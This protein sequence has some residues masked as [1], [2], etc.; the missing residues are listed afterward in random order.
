MDLQKYKWVFTVGALVSSSYL[1][2]RAATY[3]A[4]SAILEQIQEGAPKI[5]AAKPGIKKA[6]EAHKSSDPITKRNIFDSQASSQPA[7][8]ASAPTEAAPILSDAPPDCTNATVDPSGATLKGTIVAF[9]DSDSN[10]TLAESGA[11]GT[12]IYWMGEKAFNGEAEVYQ[13]R[14]KKVF[15]KRATGC[16][17]LALGETGVPKAVAAPVAPVVAGADAAITTEGINKTGENSYEISRDLINSKLSDLAALTT[18]A[19]A[20][21][22]MKNGEFNGF[23]LYAIRSTSVFAQIGLKNG[24]IIQSVNGERVDSLEKAMQLLDTFKSASNVQLGLQ[25]RGAQTTMDYSIR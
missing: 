3:Y 18:E 4:D 23:K 11:K 13:V 17:Y 6:S 25:R 7:T 12:S 21:P 15:F 19:K 8:P 24:D 22:N 5:T 1:T 9:P 20:I 10:V 14:A 16:T 2:A